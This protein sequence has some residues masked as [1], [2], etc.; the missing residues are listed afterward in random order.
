MKRLAFI[1]A[2]H[3]GQCAHLRNYADI[4]EC[5]VVAI[6]ELREGLGKKVAQRYGKPVLLT[7]HARKMHDDGV[8]F[9]CTGNDV[10]LTDHVPARYL[11]FPAK[12]VLN[13]ESQNELMP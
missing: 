6:A 7:I 1:G 10:W 5:E 3:M 11:N 4:R 2:G 13:E 12:A 9:Y 8:V